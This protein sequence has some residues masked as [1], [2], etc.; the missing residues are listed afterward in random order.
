[1]KSAK[2]E[3]ETK[4]RMIKRQEQEGKKKIRNQKMVKETQRCKMLTE[5]WK[6]HTQFW[7]KYKHTTPGNA[8]LSLYFQKH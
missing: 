6:T 1:M 2:S 7:C 4:G 8:D 5:T 3:D